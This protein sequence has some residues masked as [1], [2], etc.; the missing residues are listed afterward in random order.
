VS[1]SQPDFMPRVF[2]VEEGAD[3][4]AFYAGPTEHPAPRRFTKFCLFTFTPE[5]K[6]A[7]RVT[8]VD[9]PDIPPATGF[10]PD[11]HKPA[12]AAE[13]PD[14]SIWLLVP[15]DNNGVLPNPAK[16]GGY[17]LVQIVNGVKGHVYTHEFEW[18][19]MDE[20]ES[21]TIA[22][23]VGPDGSVY[24]LRRKVAHSF[25]EFCSFS[26]GETII[27][28]WSPDGVRTVL[29]SE[30]FSGHRCLFANEDT[31]YSNEGF[32][33]GQPGGSPFAR[34]NM[35]CGRNGLYFMHFTGS[36]FSTAFP[37]Y[38]EDRITG[39]V[40]RVGYDGGLE[41]SVFLPEV[42]NPPGLFFISLGE[43][44]SGADPRRSD[45]EAT[46]LYRD[47]EQSQP[48]V[49]PNTPTMNKMRVLRVKS[50]W[51]FEI[52]NASGGE[53]IASEELTRS[54]DGV[55]YV[56]RFKRDDMGWFDPPDPKVV[57]LLK[58]TGESFAWSV[59]AS[60]QPVAD[61]LVSGEVVIGPRFVGR[62]FLK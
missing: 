36:G 27:D 34:G 45:I 14:G 62:H 37:T 24:V 21:H 13:S 52:I 56:P 1:L 2:E 10:N 58:Q 20:Q 54:V 35:P 32:S 5:V 4:W 11:D 51:G 9:E 47:V 48:H 46:F 12:D 60:M 61:E 30:A 3:F 28:R 23:A 31:E 33:P 16:R 53:E 19:P 17:R 15:R 7:R 41:R 50:P 25:T 26:E 57:Y 43:W 42:T 29:Y 59:G 38:S 6:L 22:L 55:L 8:I 49:Y 18:G 44:H 40:S 39:H